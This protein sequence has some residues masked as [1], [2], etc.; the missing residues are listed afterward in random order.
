MLNS[1]CGHQL[2]FVGLKCHNE[3]DFRLAQIH[4]REF[5]FQTGTHNTILA[6]GDVLFQF[7]TSANIIFRTFFAR[8][9]LPSLFYFNPKMLLSHKKWNSNFE[10]LQSATM[11]KNSCISSWGAWLS[12]G[13][14]YRVKFGK[15][16]W[17][18]HFLKKKIFQ[19]IE[20]FLML[21][22]ENHSWRKKNPVTVREEVWPSLVKIAAFPALCV[23]SLDVEI[24]LC[25]TSPYKELWML[26]SIEKF[27]SS[28]LLHLNRNWNHWSCTFSL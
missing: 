24:Y 14:L 28:I 15:C 9:P 8:N 17:I 11:I 21:H 12:N 16:I 26:N 25:V 7:E 18:Y 27:K 4:W 1:H 19:F 5:P 23:S 13:I 22:K 10:V 2:S 20:N 6:G 3:A